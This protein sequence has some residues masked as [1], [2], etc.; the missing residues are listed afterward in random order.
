MSVTFPTS[1][2]LSPQQLAVLSWVQS[3][4]GSLNLIAY[5]GTGKTFTLM[6]IAKVI[7][8]PAFM[9]AFNKSIADEFKERLSA[10][11]AYHVK[12]ATIHSAGLEAWK[13]KLD[14]F[15][16]LAA[17]FDKLTVKARKMLA[18][19]EARASRKK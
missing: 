14:R 4:S 12:G 5:A 1:S 7:K 18:K 2:T 3:G 11:R 8:E 15:R 19:E 10:I 17:D 13:T 9:G 6:E 16:S